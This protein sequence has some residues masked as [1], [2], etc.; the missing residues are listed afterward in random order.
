MPM[1]RGARSTPGRARPGAGALALVRR[2]VRLAPE[3]EQREALS[4]TSQRRRENAKRTTEREAQALF[5]E[6]S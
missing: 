6:K 3:A 1:R 4:I 2:T 5:K